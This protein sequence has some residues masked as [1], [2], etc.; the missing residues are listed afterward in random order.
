MTEKI[1]KPKIPVDDNGDGEE[2]GDEEGTEIQLGPPPAYPTGI[3]PVE[4]PI[5]PAPPMEPPLNIPKPPMTFNLPPPVPPANTSSVPVAREKPKK[6]FFGLGS[7]KK[8]NKKA[9]K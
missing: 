4:P 8:S 5:P 1:P 6:T 3:E 9:S 7:K 2:S